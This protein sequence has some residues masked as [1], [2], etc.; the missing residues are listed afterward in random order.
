MAAK[1]TVTKIKAPAIRKS[2]TKNA[3]PTKLKQGNPYGK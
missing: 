3:P 1:P 2:T